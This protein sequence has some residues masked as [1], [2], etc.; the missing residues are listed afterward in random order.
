[1]ICYKNDTVERA[2]AQIQRDP[3]LSILL[4]FWHHHWPEHTLITES[5]RP[6]RH[7]G[8]LHSL[9]P[10]RA[11]DLRSFTF[12]NPITIANLF[13][14]EWIYDPDRP[15]KSCCV[16]HGEHKHFHLQVHP[17][18][19]RRV[20]YETILAVNNDAAGHKLRQHQGG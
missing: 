2:A 9:V 6:A 12:G 14:S 3:K 11:I 15:E 10:Y 7:P 4:T 13:N 17:H 20:D 8:D 18:T 19:I 5:W 16:Y 1:M